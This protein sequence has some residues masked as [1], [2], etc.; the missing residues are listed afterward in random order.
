MLL[1][2]LWWLCRFGFALEN[3]PSNTTIAIVTIQR[4]ENTF[5]FEEISYSLLFLGVKRDLVN[6]VCR[7]AKE[8]HF[9]IMPFLDLIFTLLA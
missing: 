8:L 5:V 1:L 7:T 4:N 9:E 2:D 3:T 6:G